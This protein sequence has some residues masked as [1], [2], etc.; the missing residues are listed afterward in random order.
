M[1][2]KTFFL[3]L[4]YISQI[5]FAQAGNFVIQ[6]HDFMT[7]YNLNNHQAMITPVP[8]AGSFWPYGKNGI[9]AKDPGSVLSPTELYDFLLQQKNLATD[10]E[11]KNHSCNE[12][13]EKYKEGCKA[14]WGHCNAWAAAAVSRSEPR[15]QFSIRG[16]PVTVSHQKGLL[17][18]IYMSVGSLF[19]GNTNKSIKT[20]I[21]VCDP[22]SEIAKKR[23]RYGSTNYEA[24]WDISPRDTFLILTNYIG[25]LNKGVVIDRFTG[26]EVWNQPVVAYKMAP[27][28]EDQVSFDAIQNIST[29]PVELT[30]YWANDN[31]PTNHLSEAFNMNAGYS[32]SYTSR[33]LK[34]KL[35]MDGKVQFENGNIKSA[36]KI[37]GKGIWMHQEECADYNAVDLNHS[38]YDFIWSPTDIAPWGSANPYI[39]AEN[40]GKILEGKDPVGPVTPADPLDQWKN[41]AFTLEGVKLADYSPAILKKWIKK[42][43]SRE[44][45]TSYVYL[46]DLI[47]VDPN[48]GKISGKIKVPR[49]TNVADFETI[50]I[51][52]GTKILDLKEF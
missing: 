37:L 4:I 7:L 23:D 11:N 52:L 29:V 49:N 26:D 35:L 51:S 10:W 44:N 13:E 45:I 46:K 3:F 9:S 21:W 12:I 31:V 34:F 33:T 14:W 15:T 41:F 47:V 5:T 39:Q 30:V 20:D 36:G 22:D 50:L 43:L 38:H 32:W 42:I 18:E 6:E 48:S 16:K 25:L 2:Q 17:T 24:F 27:I 8:W 40:V 1:K 19:A 28:I